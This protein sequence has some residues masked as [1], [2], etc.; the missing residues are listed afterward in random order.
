MSSGTL[1]RFAG[2]SL[3]LPTL[4]GCAALASVAG[5]IGLLVLLPMLFVGL[6]L[7]ALWLQKRTPPG[8]G[9]ADQRRYPDYRGDRDG[10]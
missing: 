3:L 1:L 5:R 9:D 7:L 2:L 10:D 8:R 6:F 4:P